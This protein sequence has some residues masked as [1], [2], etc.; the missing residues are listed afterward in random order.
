V[1]ETNRKRSSKKQS[2]YTSNLL[3]VVVFILIILL[4]VTAIYASTI[5]QNDNKPNDTGDDFSFT[6]LDGS[7]DKLSNYRGK[8]VV[9]DMWTIWCGYC[10]DQIYELIE[11]YD[12]YDPEDIEILSIDVD[13]RETASDIQ[14]FIDQTFESQ[15]YNIEWTFGLDHNGN[16]WETYRGA[17]GGIPALCIFDKNGNLYYQHEGLERAS[18]LAEKIDELLIS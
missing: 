8:I 7:E 10:D 13:Q 9:L 16:I 2:S 14:N 4:V 11:I 3:L 1:N 15:G 17:Q 18:A 5:N 12:I 6:Q